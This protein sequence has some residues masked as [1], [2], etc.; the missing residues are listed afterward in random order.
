MLER[1]GGVIRLFVFLFKDIVG[2]RSELVF[3]KMRSVL[4]KCFL[5]VIIRRCESLGV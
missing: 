2:R 4:E 1:L 3:S 5:F